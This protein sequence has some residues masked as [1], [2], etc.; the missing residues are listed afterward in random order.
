MKMAEEQARSVTGKS[1]AIQALILD[2]RADLASLRPD[3]QAVSTGGEVARKLRP[4]HACSDRVFPFTLLSHSLAA[5]FSHLKYGLELVG[6]EEGAYPPAVLAGAQRRR[7][8]W[9]VLA[10][11]E[12]RAQCQEVEI[13][14]MKTELVKTE[15]EKARAEAEKEQHIQ[16]SRIQ[17]DKEKA[18]IEKEQQL[19]IARMQSEQEKAMMAQQ[20]E[21]GNLSGNMKK[22]CII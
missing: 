2:E 20:E 5:C 13:M 19:E 21:R 15:A 11:A 4:L 22:K 10:D 14:R 16:L 12:Q 3:W 8:S 9:N 7:T 1:L 17:A 6:K 18:N